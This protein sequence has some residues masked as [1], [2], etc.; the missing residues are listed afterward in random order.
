MLDH[1][2]RR[3]LIPRAKRVSGFTMIEMVVTMGIFAI[4]VALAV[5]TMRTWI[6]NSKVRAVS[7]ALQ[8]GLRLAQSESLRRSRQ[9]TFELTNN[10]AAP[11][12]AV[13]N[14][15]YWAIYTIPSMTDGT[16]TGVFVESGVLA[17]VG[18]NV[19]VTG[20]AAICFNSVG[21]PV[22]N[23]SGTLTTV[24]GGASCTLPAAS[25]YN[26]TVTGADRPLRVN[27]STGGEVHMCVPTLALSTS[28]PDGC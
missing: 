5:P 28:N 21:R 25:T 16:E 10:T 7:D 8:N 6:S 2:A 26:V 13:A 20:P 12:T 23:A 14:G 11:F 3:M 19:T 18:S 9:V 27:L 17:A 24:T 1:E 15:K 22:L 4:L